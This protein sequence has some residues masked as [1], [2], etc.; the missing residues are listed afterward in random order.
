LA[1]NFTELFDFIPGMEK[2]S[3]QLT[4]NL[5]VFNPKIVISS[6]EIWMGPGIRDEKKLNPDP[7]VKKHRILGPNPQNWMVPTISCWS[8]GYLGSAVGSRALNLKR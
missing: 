5:G 7:E 8:E 6:Q 4:Q 1:L 2:D 3:S